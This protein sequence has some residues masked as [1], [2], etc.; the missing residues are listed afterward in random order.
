MNLLQNRLIWLI[1]LVWWCLLWLVERILLVR[2]LLGIHV[3][4]L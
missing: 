2:G 1:Q 3:G 4:L